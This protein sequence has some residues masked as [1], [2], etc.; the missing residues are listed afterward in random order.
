[1]PGN[2]QKKT[3][4][5][6]LDKYYHLAKEQGYRSRA[7]FKL[8]QLN[9][10]YD[11]L[12]K[13]GVL[14]DLCAA[15]GGW[16]Q[17]ASKTMPASSLII[18]VDLDPIRAIPNVKTFVGDI[19]TQKCRTTLRSLL[20]GAK[21]SK[22][23]VDVVLH[24][25]APNLG[26]AWGRDALN[27]AELVLHSV[28]LASEFLIEGGTFVSKVF[29]SAEYTALLW[30]FQQL[31]DKVEA[32]KPLSSRN[33]SA[34]IFVICR[35]YKAPDKID[36]R[37]LDPKHVFEQVE[38]PKTKPDVFHKKL[39]RKVRNREGYDESLGMGL[40]RR[41]SV[42][43]FVESE[44]PVRV[45]SDYHQLEFDARSEVYKRHEATTSETVECCHDLQVLGKA[46]FKMLLQWRKTM[47]AHRDELLAVAGG[48]DA[49][50]VAASAASAAGAAASGLQGKANANGG[51]GERNEEHDKDDD[52]DDDD[53]DSDAREEQELD[54]KL[55]AAVKKQAGILRRKKKK[56]ARVKAKNRMRMALGMNET[57]VDLD[58]VGGMQDDELFKVSVAKTAEDVAL[59]NRVKLGE[60]AVDELNSAAMQHVADEAEAEADRPFPQGRPPSMRPDVE[61][62]DSDEDSGD[63]QRDMED[64][65]EREFQARK[66]KKKL[67]E[68]V[69]EERY[70]VMR[71]V[72]GKKRREEMWL[73]KVMADKV[74]ETD[75][76]QDQYKRSVRDANSDDDDDGDDDRDDDDDDD[77]DEEL[78]AAEVPR[79][80]PAELF[81][82]RT[83]R[84]ALVD[85]LGTRAAESAGAV[86]KWFNNPIFKIDAESGDISL[87]AP[88]SERQKR[89]D[90]H[91][92][93]RERDAAKAALR[94][95]RDLAKHGGATNTVDGQLGDEE[96]DHLAGMTGGDGQKVRVRTVKQGKA[97]LVMNPA[98]LA[99][100]AEENENDENEDNSDD[101]NQKR[102]RKRKVQSSSS[103]RSSSSTAETAQA[104]ATKAKL[105]KTE[106]DHD[107]LDA[108]RSVD[109]KM[110]NALRL[111]G[112]D[113]VFRQLSK[114]EKDSLTLD[115][116]NELPTA[117]SAAPP[118]PRPPPPGGGQGGK[119]DGD[120]DGD[121]DDDDEKDSKRRKTSK[122]K[123]R[124]LPAA[125]KEAAAAAAS[126]AGAGGGAGAAAVLQAP[127]VRNPAVARGMAK[128]AAK[129]AA[130]PNL[131]R[132]SELEKTHDEM[133]LEDLEDVRIGSDEHAE[134]L[135]TGKLMMMAG[136]SGTAALVDAAY[137]KYCHNDV[138]LPTWFIEDENKHFRPQMPV[139]KAMVEEIKQQFADLA[140]KP[141]KKVAEAR[142][143]KRSRAQ[144]KLRKA[145][146]RVAQVMAA[147]EISDAS[148]LK[149]IRKIYKRAEV[150][151]AEKKYVV[152]GAN[153]SIGN[154][155]GGFG[156][157]F[158]D[159]RLKNDKKMAA[160]AASGSKKPKRT[161]TIHSR[162]RRNRK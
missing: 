72:V 12:S 1:M 126:G 161:K 134:I 149:E 124:S 4:K 122:K 40:H 118:P 63:F 155:K 101:D 70:S 49:A 139:T 61:A 153:K 115:T 21:E 65:F 142:A 27:Q 75:N 125:R 121:D 137:N 33:T 78:Q 41:C 138:D 84:A 28:K 34:E 92:R 5:G 108:L 135:A 6:R 39:G 10:K 18:G 119:D 7:A 159:S 8:I 145:K 36:P 87:N 95:Q 44:D 77:D 79:V 3:G 26:G 68:A 24:D 105:T 73:D 2:K 48:G 62:A 104:T 53:A 112:Y 9:K 128:L 143:R 23:K 147:P 56:E 52:D 123:Q 14:L 54:Q 97:S 64:Q 89:K 110:K 156:T 51:A 144:A 151:E 69:L 136:R 140:N 111:A 141:I 154:R 117:A 107:N 106:I 162:S 22:G 102:S 46:D 71:G 85:D 150:K 88:R 113:K 146:T 37:M 13:C 30:V 32:T 76:E 100:T 58:A 129:Q 82:K 29:R 103:S 158:V 59:I 90:R 120:E 80:D 17:V 60:G 94:E 38:A 67:H 91:K 81:E 131:L 19:T 157:R 35:Q 45:L 152:S 57:S 132:V 148:K 43:D 15:P 160:K 109:K 127:L 11:F 42:A 133:A 83:K 20:G 66:E 74:M 16:L 31:F 96:G 93:Q 99:R 50:A 47:K 55:S 98:L 114:L 25:G 86:D 116:S 130:P